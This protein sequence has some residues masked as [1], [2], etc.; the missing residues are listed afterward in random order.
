MTDTIGRAA[1]LHEYD[2]PFTIEEYPLPTPDPGG[3]LV[4]IDVATVCGSDVHVWLGHLAATMPITPPLILG[5]EMVGIITTLGDGVTED[6]LGN[7]LAVGDRIVWAHRSCGHCHECTVSKQPQLCTHRYVGYLN[8]CSVPPHFTGTFAEYSYVVP[9]AGTLRVPDGVKSTWASAASCAL[10]TVVKAAQVAGRI[11]SQESVLIQGAGPLGLFATALLAA[12]GPRQ[13]IVVGGPDDRLDLARAWGATDTVSVTEHPDGPSRVA[14]V[15]ELTGGAGVDVGFEFAGVNGAVAEG[16]EMLR[17]NGRYVVMGTL[18][19]GVQTVDAA[20]IT[21]RGLRISGSMS[22]EIGDYHEALQFMDRYQDRYEW[23]RMIGN[24]YPLDQVA[25]A[26]ASMRS[27]R[28]IKP[29]IRP[30][31]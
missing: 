10:R 31:R 9:G 15:R 25:E 3:L 27:M 13:I 5:H 6:S 4:R 16:V 26:M 19:N 30:G 11:D 12:G 29:V 22:G 24:E 1:V 14:R 7:P 8:D 20:M 21:T 28:E 23:D 18:G 2:T 17:R